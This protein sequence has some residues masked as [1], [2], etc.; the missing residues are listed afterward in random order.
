[1]LLSALVS[2]VDSLLSVCVWDVHLKMGHLKTSWKQFLSI[3]K[4]PTC[5][6]LHTIGWVNDSYQAEICLFKAKM[7]TSSKSW[8]C[9]L[10]ECTSIY[11][12]TK[13]SWGLWMR[14]LIYLA[15]LFLVPVSWKN[16]PVQQSD[17]M[18][19]NDV[20]Q[21]C[22]DSHCDFSSV[23]D[24]RRS[25]ASENTRGSSAPWTRSL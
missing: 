24:G 2:L 18:C 12:A 6:S 23:R 11:E 10:Q 25:R 19:N 1:M 20:K 15:V 9:Q 8:F 3:L 17:V 14:V 7:Y 4:Q 22:T 13:L 16:F 21:S 5:F